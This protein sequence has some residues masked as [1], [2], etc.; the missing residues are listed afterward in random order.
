MDIESKKAL[1]RVQSITLD[2][3]Q[4]DLSKWTSL[5]VSLLDKTAIKTCFD[6][7]EEN[8]EMSTL[9]LGEKKKLEPLFKLIIEWINNELAESRIIVKDLQEDLYDGYILQLLLGIQF[10][11]KF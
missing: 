10:K 9:G 4:Y 2:P 11:S 5:S 3:E 7:I 1:D 8:D 6:K